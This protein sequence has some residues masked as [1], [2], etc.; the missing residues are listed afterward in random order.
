MTRRMPQ[1]QQL[2]RPC[3]G[4][5]ETLDMSRSCTRFASPDGAGARERDVISARTFSRTVSPRNSC[6]VS[7]V[8]GCR[9]ITVLSSLR[10]SSTTSRLGDFLRSRMAVLKSFFG[11]SFLTSGDL[12]VSDCQ[13]TQT[14]LEAD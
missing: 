4:A 11:A 9:A 2:G 1:A 8:L 12:H 13:R 14:Q 5:M 3:Y 6:S 7:I 10:A